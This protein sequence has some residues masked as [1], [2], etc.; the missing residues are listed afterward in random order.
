MRGEVRY[1]GAYALPQRGETLS[2]LVERAGGLRPEAFPE[3]AVLRRLG[4]VVAL[5]VPSDAVLEPVV[6][7]LS[8]ALRTPGSEADLVLREGDELFIPS[9][10]GAVTVAGAVR[11]PATLQHRAALKLSDYLASCGGLIDAAD[12][13][14]ITI[15][16]P[17]NASR[18]VAKGQD[19]VLVPG[20]TI[21]VPLA[22]AT[23]RLRVVEVKGAVAQPAIVQFTESARLGYYLTACGGFTANADVERVSVLLPDGR[24][25]R[26]MPGAAFDPEVPAGATIIVTA[27]AGAEPT[28][29]S[30]P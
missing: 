5:G 29:A 16:A 24:I 15:T 19:P 22:R 26:G 9:S 25:L 27:K 12:A 1:P 18:L 2:H 30:A 23:E 10:S 17:N 8:A 3:G 13:A 14:R 28:A 11:S 4:S 20:S 6:I 21:D 7:D